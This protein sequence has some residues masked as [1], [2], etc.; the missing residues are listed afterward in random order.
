MR[1]IIEGK[2]LFSLEKVICFNVWVEY[3]HKCI[4]IEENIYAYI[5]HYCIAVW[6]AKHQTTYCLLVCNPLAM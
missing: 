1:L 5:Q 4:T 2:E 6:A 3:L